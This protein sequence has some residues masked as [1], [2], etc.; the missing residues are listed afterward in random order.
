[1]EKSKEKDP[2][3][4]YLLEDVNEILNKYYLGVDVP[5]EYKTLYLYITEH[6]EKEIESFEHPILNDSS[7]SKKYKDN[8]PNGW[9]GFS[10]GNPTP[11]NWYIAIDKIV[12]FLIKKDPDF[13]IHQ[14]KMKFGGIR[15]YCESE[16]IVDIFDISRAIENTL[17]NKKLIW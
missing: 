14:I 3:K 10:I 8:I 13:E 15:F 7:L 6:P 5:D 11:M 4:L 16:L 17:Y 2:N 12:D 1:M 9:Y